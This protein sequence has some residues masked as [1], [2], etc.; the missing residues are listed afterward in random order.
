MITGNNMYS[1][2]YAILK[3]N[4]LDPDQVTINLNDRMELLTISYSHKEDMY[5]LYREY[6][7]SYN[8]ILYSNY[9]LDGTGKQL[10]KNQFPVDNIGRQLQKHRLLIIK[11]CG[12]RK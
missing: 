2:L 11:E 5:T 10:S 8:D 6:V 4:K 1:T 7:I 9:T 3:S 12:L